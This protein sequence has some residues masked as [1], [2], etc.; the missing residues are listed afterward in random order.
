MFN[1][2]P[3]SAFFIPVCDFLKAGAFDELPFRKGDRIEVTKHSDD[4]WWIGKLN[5]MEGLFPV[6]AVQAVVEKK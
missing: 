5:D 1:V 2:Y 3:I 6:N 4:G